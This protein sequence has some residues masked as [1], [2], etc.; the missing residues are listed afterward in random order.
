MLRL[1]LLRGRGKFSAC[2]P[3]RQTKRTRSRVH[4]ASSD[5]ICHLLSHRRLDCVRSAPSQLKAAAMFGILTGVNDCYVN[6]LFSTT[7]RWACCFLHI[8]NTSLCDD[9]KLS[10]QVLILTTATQQLSV[11]ALPSGQHGCYR[12]ATCADQHQH[13]LLA[14]L[15]TGTDAGRCCW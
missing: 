10:R 9:V 8:S 3:E 6:I 11:Q 15:L 5:P 14:S 7:G 12:P 4:S 13:W 1:H 2:E